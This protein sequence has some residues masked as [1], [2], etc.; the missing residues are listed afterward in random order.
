MQREENDAGQQDSMRAYK[1]N[2]A[3]QLKEING[4]ACKWINPVKP[5]THKLKLLH[6]SSGFVLYKSKTVSRF[7]HS[8]V[9]R[10]DLAFTSQI[11]L[12]S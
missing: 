4:R 10:P 1:A 8:G 6:L 11:C 7:A 5:S 2:Y 3:G 12:G 9:L